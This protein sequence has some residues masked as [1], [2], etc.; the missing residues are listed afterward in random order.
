MYTIDKKKVHGLGISQQKSLHWTVENFTG[1]VWDG[2]QSHYLVIVQ[3]FVGWKTDAWRVRKGFV[4]FHSNLSPIGI[5]IFSCSRPKPP[6]RTHIRLLNFIFFTT[7]Q[8]IIITY[9]CCWLCFDLYVFC[10]HN[11][12]HKPL[13]LLNNIHILTNLSDFIYSIDGISDHFLFCSWFHIVIID[14]QYF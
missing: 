4:H 9:S 7:T 6:P 1:R 14:A 8:Y 2:E 11:F 5:I 12:V 13:A 3:C 10:A